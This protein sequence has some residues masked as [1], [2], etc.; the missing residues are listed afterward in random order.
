MD[1]VVSISM[2][3]WREGQRSFEPH[4]LDRTVHTLH[5]SR[6]PLL[7]PSQ[8]R[9]V[10]HCWHQLTG[11]E[12]AILQTGRFTLIP[13]AGTAVTIATAIAVFCAALVQA[14]AAVHVGVSLQAVPGEGC[15]QGEAL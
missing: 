13:I 6:Q 5:E 3:G 2:L 12:L 11:C 10:D 14:D 9:K 7:G 15:L 4:E 1:F 8:I